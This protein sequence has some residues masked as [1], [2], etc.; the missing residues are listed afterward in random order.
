[1][2]RIPAHRTLAQMLPK[3]TEGGKEFA[4]TSTGFGFRSPTFDTIRWLNSE[5]P[6]LSSLLAIGMQAV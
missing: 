1:M 4:R 6:K 5:C 2:K 3:G